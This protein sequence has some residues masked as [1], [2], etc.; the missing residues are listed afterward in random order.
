MATT[1]RATVETNGKTATGIEVPPEVI[2]ALGSGKRPKVKVSF[3]DYSYS[4]TV[5]VMGGRFLLPVSAK[6]RDE[7]GVAAGDE[8][9]ITLELD[10]APRELEVP[11]DLAAALAAE[12]AAKAFFDSLSYSQ[13]RWFVE[14]VTSAKKAETRE[15]RVVAA[16]ERLAAGRGQ[17]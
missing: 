6:V 17:R 7:S 16:V 12:P 10:D 13:R 3:A 9:E 5:G 8:L 15:R 2:E 4:I 14:S 11:D 1:F